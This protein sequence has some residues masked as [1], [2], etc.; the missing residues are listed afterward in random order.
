[1]VIRAEEKTLYL[2]LPR[3]VVDVVLPATPLRWRDMQPPSIA[4]VGRSCEK[5]DLE[6]LW[7]RR[8]PGRLT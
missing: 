2:V 1:M 4:I 8:M 6:R 5:E 3:V 7:Q